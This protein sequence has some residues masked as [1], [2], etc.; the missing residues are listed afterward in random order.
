MEPKRPASTRKV[1]GLSED[2]PGR[3]HEEKPLTP[4]ERAETA[5]ALAAEAVNE[6]LLVVE[7]LSGE[8]EANEAPPPKS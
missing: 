1:M 7:E 4:Q 8:P 5:A 6:L 3:K 2:A